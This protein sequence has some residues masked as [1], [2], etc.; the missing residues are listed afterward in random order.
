L[1]RLILVLQQFFFSKHNNLDISVA[2]IVFPSLAVVLQ[3]NSKHLNIDLSVNTVVFLS[4]L[5]LFVFFW[6]D[7]LLT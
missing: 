5:V 2:S 7:Y 6:N 3:L 4:N 1:T